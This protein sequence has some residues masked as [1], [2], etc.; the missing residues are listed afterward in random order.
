M[1]ECPKMSNCVKYYLISVNLLQI[2]K[3]DNHYYGIANK[4]RQPCSQPY[5][6]L[7]GE[8]TIEQLSGGGRVRTKKRKVV[9]HEDT[10]MKLME[11]FTRGIRTLELFSSM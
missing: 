9:R 7:S 3:E 4:W 11:E 5:N 1:W 2:R 10:I 6:H 8:V